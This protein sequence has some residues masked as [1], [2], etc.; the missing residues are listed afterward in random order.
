MRPATFRSATPAG[1][2]HTAVLAVLAALGA[3]LLWTAPAAAQEPGTRPA[4][5]SILLLNGLGVSTL[6]AGIG[7]NPLARRLWQDGYEVTVDSHT[8]VRSAGMAPDVIIGHSMGGVAALRY[9][10]R[11]VAGG[12]PEP[13]V[14]TIDAAPA[15]PPCPV[16][17][18]YAIRGAGFAP[19]PGAVNI[20]ARALGARASSHLRLPTDPAVETYIMERAVG[21]PPAA[22]LS[23]GFFAYD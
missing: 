16:R 8:M 6:N 11:L 20:T 17:R 5:P 22:V 9:A 18:C 2:A 7:L 1:R 21:G 19:V 13:V 4:G 23:S 14:I 3:A 15:A 12:A 10:A